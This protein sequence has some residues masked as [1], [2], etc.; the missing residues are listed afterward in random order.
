MQCEG[1]SFCFVLG[2]VKR[3]VSFLVSSGYLGTRNVFG[4]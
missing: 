2:F 3:F 1:F 4:V